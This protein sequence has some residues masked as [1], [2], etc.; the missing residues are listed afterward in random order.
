M[1]LHNALGLCAVTLSAA[2][3]VLAFRAAIPA[4]RL[5][6]ELKR[7]RKQREGGS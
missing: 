6:L 7:E 2:A 3:V 4:T 1:T 5:Y